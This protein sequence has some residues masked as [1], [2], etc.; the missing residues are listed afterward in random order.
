MG[1]IHE[2]NMRDKN[3]KVLLRRSANFS[4]EYQVKQ[5]IG[6]AI[7]LARVEGKDRTLRVDDWIDESVASELARSY[8]VTTQGA[9][10]R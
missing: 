1:E 5:I 7:L 2:Q 8:D 10:K 9:S 4:N 6:P 3:T